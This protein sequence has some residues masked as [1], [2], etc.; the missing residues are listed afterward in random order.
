MYNNLALQGGIIMSEKQTINSSIQKLYWKDVRE[1]VAKLQPDVAKIIDSIS[2]A[3]KYPLYRVTYPYGNLFVDEGDFFLPN[4]NGMLAPLASG[5]FPQDIKDD[6]QYANGNI[7]A[8][9]VLNH[10]IE[11]FVT[12]HKQILP[13]FLY[14]AGTIFGL[15]G[16]LSTN[17][18]FHPP[19]VFS[20]TSGARCLFMLPNIGN[21]DLHRNLHRDYGVCS[22][23]PKDLLDQ[24]GVFKEIVHHP[25]TKCNWNTQL[26]FFTNEW[27][28][29][30]KNDP[31]WCLLRSSLH[32]LAWV[33]SDYWR[34][35]MFYNF[36]ISCAESDRNLKPNPYLAD[37]LK[38]LFAIAVGAAPGFQVG[39]NDNVAPIAF[40]QKA[41]IESYGLKEY[42]PTFLCPTHSA[43]SKNDDV[44]YYSLQYPTTLE[45]S[46]KSRKIANTLRELSELKHITNIIMEEML[47]GRLKLGNTVMGQLVENIEF[48]FYHN[49]IDQHK[50]IE[51]AKE[52]P[53]KDESLLT[54]PK[55]CENRKFA[56][57]GAFVRG[58]VQIRRKSKDDR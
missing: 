6:L 21:A 50:E 26:L 12:H 39:I 5:N 20:F 27:I 34:N 53:K 18:V 37:T 36:A 52:M 28:D 11:L 15:W 10:A 23:P 48:S 24:W 56:D 22:A 8:G 41:Y 42:I 29:S 13:W 9:I 49:K 2:P 16:Y 1:D 17:G 25:A 46:P 47:R 38:H 31:A 35:Q 51:L 58:C 44:L 57:S 43:V 19:Q 54:Y 4:G 33:K 3:K 45:F 14:S 32:N 40:L 7:P 55:G 30:I